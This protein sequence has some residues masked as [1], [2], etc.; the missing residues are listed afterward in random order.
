MSSERVIVFRG[1]RRYT[2]RFEAST[3]R[4]IRAEFSRVCYYSKKTLVCARIPRP[5]TH[6]NNVTIREIDTGATG[7]SAARA[8][9]GSSRSKDGHAEE[10]DEIRNDNNG[11]TTKRREKKNSSHA[12]RER[13]EDGEARKRPRVYWTAYDEGTKAVGRDVHGIAYRSIAERKTINCPKGIRFVFYSRLP[14]RGRPTSSSLPTKTRVQYHVAF[15]NNEFCSP[16]TFSRDECT[17]D[18]TSPVLTYRA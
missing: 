7:L 9:S 8:T 15:G 13:N 14:F 5:R 1:G 10:D 4:T 12:M 6:D 18:H 11:R 2:I 3:R 16:Q 17:F